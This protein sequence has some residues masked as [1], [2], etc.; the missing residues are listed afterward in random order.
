MNEKITENGLPRPKFH[1]DT[2]WRSKSE[3]AL[4]VKVEVLTPI[5][6]SGKNDTG[7]RSFKS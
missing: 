1:I 7:P 2:S 6:E 3:D 4:N 5:K